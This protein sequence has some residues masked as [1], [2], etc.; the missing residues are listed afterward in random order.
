MIPQ[1]RLESPLNK[2]DILHVLNMQ[3]VTSVKI[4]C[5]V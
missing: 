1:Q 4:L 3:N 2:H 5:M